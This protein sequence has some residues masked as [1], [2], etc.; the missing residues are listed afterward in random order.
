MADSQ[1]QLLSGQLSYEG[2]KSVRINL[3]MARCANGFEVMVSERWVG[4]T[5]DLAIPAGAK[6]ELRVDGEAVITGHVDSTRL[7]IDAGAHGVEINGR[8]A[9]GDLVDCSAIR[10]SGQWRGLRIE[11]IAAELA[12]PYGVSVRADVDTGKALSSFALQEGETV[13]EAIE[14]AARIRALLLVS[15]GL[16]SLVITRAS[17][18]LLDTSLVLGVNML[19]GRAGLDLRDRFS[20]YTL[21]GQVPAGNYLSAKAASQVKAT[22]TD[23]GVPRYRPLIVTND[24][25]D[26]AASLVQRAIW[27]ANVRAARSHDVEVTVQGW[28]HAAGIWR[29]NSLVR[30]VAK[31]LRLDDDLLITDVELSL[32]DRGS[33]ATLRLTRADAFSLL[34]MK[35]TTGPTRYFDFPKKPAAEKAAQ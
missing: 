25:P 12:E 9:T 8:D 10:K 30:V 1:V 3:G 2:W 28:R 18:E 32:D 4:Q 26:V 35:A 19:S 29:P 13:F 17:S 16:G 23:P 31:P 33:T 27:E 7:S 21:K 11:Q 22:A 6:C 14:R 5:Q 15:D 24:S 34:P 20:T